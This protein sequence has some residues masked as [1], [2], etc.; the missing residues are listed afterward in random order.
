MAPRM[1]RCICTMA[2]RHPGVRDGVWPV[3][4]CEADVMRAR[5]QRSACE[6]ACAGERGACAAEGMPC[7]S[8]RGGVDGGW[9]KAPLRTL[10]QHLELLHGYIFYLVK[11][12]K[13]EF[14]VIRF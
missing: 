13:I 14:R 2:P 5:R 3:N 7:S 4:A 10:L 1:P 8:C 12:G 11:H 9:W 6:G